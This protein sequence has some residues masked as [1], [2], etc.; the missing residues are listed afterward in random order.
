MGLEPS[1]DVLLLDRATPEMVNGLWNIVLSTLSFTYED[2]GVWRPTSLVELVAVEHYRYPADTLPS[3]WSELRNWLRTTFTKEAI[4]DWRRLYDMI[5]FL[6]GN[7]ERLPREQNHKFEVF[8]ARVN[9][10][11]EDERSAFRLLD[12]K[13]VPI[14][15]ASELHAISEVGELANNLGLEQARVHL[16]AAVSELAV[17]PTPNFRNCI[18]EAINAVEVVASQLAG[19]KKAALPKALGKLETKAGIH[20]QLKTAF[21]NMYNYTSGESGIRHCIMDENNV[22]LT[23]AKFMLV[24]CSAFVHYMI[25]K[26]RDAGMLAG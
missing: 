3:Y 5:E 19:E 26:A 18:K 8:G 6:A 14:T 9:D 11:L 23:E 20:S 15:N 21:T 13:V 2:V 24:S 17:R 1:T 7:W 25:M 10:L 4:G 12:R 22:G 16:T